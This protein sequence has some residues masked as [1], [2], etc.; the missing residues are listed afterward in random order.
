MQ[1]MSVWR[2]ITLRRRR[3]FTA[4]LGLSIGVCLLLVLHS[5]SGAYKEATRMPLQDVGADIS[6]QRNGDVPEEL[7]G[8]VFPCSAVTIR[9][10]EIEE[11]RSM[12]GVRSVAQAVLLWVFQGDKF[13]M[14]LGIEPDN[15]LGPGKLK[16]MVVKGSFIEA[17]K[18]QAVVDASFARDQGIEVGDIVTIGDRIFPVIGLVAA[19]QASKMAVAHVYIPLSEAQALAVASKGVQ[20]VS[21]FAS[22]DANVVFVLADQEAIPQLS[23]SLR[24]VLGDKAAI[25][26]PETFLRK[27]GTLFAL[28]DRFAAATGMIVL[29]VAF[30]LVL[31][32]VTGG[33]QERSREI[34]VLKCLGWTKGCLRMQIAAETLAQCL[35]AAV[36]GSILA[37]IACWLLS[38]QTLD[39]LI[40]WEMNPTP[41]FLPGGSEP[42][43]RSVRLPVR[44]SLSALVVALGLSLGV[45]G[46]T[47]LLCTGRIIKIKPSEVLR[48]E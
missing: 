7:Q 3:H 2:E 44:L 1:C 37:A 9:H 38:F 5:I 29:A 15:L 14:V 47:S 4:I 17:N 16:N 12:N 30:L 27:L 10:D 22:Q 43:Y 31:K 34:A 46:V 18:S 48:H 24:E 39:I 41:H 33:I 19:S 11:A 23:A 13:T 36:I 28:S 21:P 42:V 32:T 6:I 26:T 35:L 45:G 25:S 8:V 40:P 20:S